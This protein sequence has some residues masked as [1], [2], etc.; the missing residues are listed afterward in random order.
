MSIRREGR[1]CEG[2][3]IIYLCNVPAVDKGSKDDFLP[4][5]L[6]REG[7]LDKVQDTHIHAHEGA[8]MEYVYSRYH[9]WRIRVQGTRKENGLAMARH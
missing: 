9:W 7:V 5:W 4:W 8:M 1:G 6:R 2:S 3:L